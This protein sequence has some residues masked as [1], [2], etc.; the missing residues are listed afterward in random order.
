MPDGVAAG[1]WIGPVQG[2]GA[3][4]VGGACERDWDWD[5]SLNPKTK[6][7]TLPA[8]V[9]TK[10]VWLWHRTRVRTGQ[11]SAE[12]SDVSSGSEVGCC[13]DM[14]VRSRMR[15][16][17]NM[18]SSRTLVPSATLQSPHHA[19]SMNTQASTSTFP[20]PVRSPPPPHISAEHLQCR[21]AIAETQTVCKLTCRS[22]PK[23]GPK[24]TQPPQTLAEEPRP[25]LT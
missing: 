11:S 18:P 12:A 1:P 8:G 21:D 16:H 23:H 2:H 19:S 25:M 24:S 5:R 13:P 17:I 7:Q 22:P 10:R 4:L 6:P 15:S 3:S 9:P 14:T 20:R